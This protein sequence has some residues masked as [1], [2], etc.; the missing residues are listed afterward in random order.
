MDA[1]QV[2]LVVLHHVL[3]DV[4]LDARDLVIVVVLAVVHHHVEVV[5]VVLEIV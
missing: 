4:I 2:V 5:P 1:I 3:A